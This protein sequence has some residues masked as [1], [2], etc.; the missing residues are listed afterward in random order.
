MK[1][2]V[3]GCSGFIGI[4]FVEEALKQ[5]HRILGWDLVEP[6]EKITDESYC[7]HKWKE[8][9]LECQEI[10]GE[11]DG[12][13]ILA[14]KR[15][16]KG[17]SMED[18]FS[19]IRL[20]MDLVDSCRKADVRNI[21]LLSSTGVYSD[22]RIPWKETEA[23]IP[24]NLYGASKLAIDEMIQL[25][26]REYGLNIK[27]L[28]LAQVIGMGE[29]KGYLL[30]T[31]IDQAIRKET[32]SIW[33]TGAGK[34]QYVYIKDVVSAILAA[35]KSER[36]GVYNIGIEGC[37]SAYDLAMVIN[38]VFDNEGNYKVYAEKPEDLQTREMDV[39]KAKRD[40]NWETAYTVKTAL[41]DIKKTVGERKDG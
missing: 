19:N 32:L 21:V 12:V 27:S 9:K 38:Q 33:G 23:N 5:K 26:N 24:A 18:Y 15:F 35:L 11:C 3:I 16:V 6:K 30:N 31:F 39:S 29:R 13:V 17:F 28:R 8:G 20:A 1:I 41:L 22:S 14:A 2:G 37:I 34:R 36:P 7:F 4:A 10:L 25:Y 40:L